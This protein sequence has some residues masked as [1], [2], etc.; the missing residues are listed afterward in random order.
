MA[1]R[2]PPSVERA[3]TRTFLRLPP[4]AL[5]RVVGP[6]HRSPDGLELD[7][8]L[9]ALLWL[10]A[11]FRVPEMAGRSVAEARAM[12]ER[13]APTLASG[14]WRDV[15]AYDRQVD[16][17]D[18]P[19]RARVY[20]PKSAPAADAPGLVFFHGGGWVVGSIESHDSLCRALASLA[21]VV[22]VSVEYRLAPEHPF[23]APPRDAI[24][25]T[26]WVLGNAALLGIDAHRVA[27]GGDSAGGNLAA[28]VAQALRADARR[29]AFQLLVYPATDMT[30]ALPSQAMFREGF[31]LSR[32][33]SDWYLGHY[34]P[35]PAD[36]TKPLASP[37]FAA[38]LSRLP[39][40]LVLTAGFDPLRD[41]GRAYAEKMRSAGVEV[42]HVCTPG[43]MH[44]FVS[45]GGAL[46][47]GARA[48]EL[49]AS[50]LRA[51]L[52]T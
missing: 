1:F 52:G 40:A 31:F 43:Q 45:L 46:R 18:G 14:P 26:R 32:A 22:V 24:A 20:V 41:E 37:L 23:P 15:A 6:A 30:R 48:V 29:P 50:R 17:A 8:Q 5:R 12:T 9:Q 49:A 13:G 35:D 44:G 42:E 7:V 10:I 51:V 16:G 3:V 21:G 25:A 34:L 38:D 19:L 27:V 28:V 11:R 4:G 47:D 36:A 33:A 2:F 39:P